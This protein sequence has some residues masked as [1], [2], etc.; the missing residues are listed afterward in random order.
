WIH[1]ELQ[2]PERALAHDRNGAEIAR[3]MGVGEAEVNSVIN[4]VIDHFQAGDRQ[5]TD[6][7]A[8]TAESILARDAWFRWRFEM[9]L[10]A[11]RAE[12]TL[13]KPDVL[14]LLEKATKYCARKYMIAARTML[15]KIALAEGDLAT[16]EAQLNS[17]LVILRE[18]PAPLIAWK[19]WSM[20]G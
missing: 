12:Q 6:S 3:S 9:R 5:Q 1:R 7:S 16:A 2:D 19:A 15:A 17:A 4:L 13:S 14:C 11:A 10:Q 20:L 8:Q 18:F